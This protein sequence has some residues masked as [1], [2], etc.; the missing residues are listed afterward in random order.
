MAFGRVGEEISPLAAGLLHFPYKLA[1]KS[2]GGLPPLALFF[3]LPQG[4]PHRPFRPPP[5]GRE[6]HAKA[7]AFLKPSQK[8]VHKP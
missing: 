1:E 2:F 3:D 4:L 6:V 8:E 5:R 7:A